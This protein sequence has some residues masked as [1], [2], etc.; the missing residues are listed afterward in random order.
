[1]SLFRDPPDGFEGSAIDSRGSILETFRSVRPD[2]GGPQIVVI[3]TTGY[4][5]PA[6]ARVLILVT[7][8]AGTLVA[9]L[10]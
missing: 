3:W 5:I 7:S 1:M 9:V 8:R 6:E 10:P 4:H 2:E